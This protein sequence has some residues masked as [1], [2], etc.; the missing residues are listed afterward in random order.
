MNKRHLIAFDLVVS[1]PNRRRLR[2]DVAMNFALDRS[3]GN[4]AR[5]DIAQRPALADLKLSHDQ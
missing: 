4:L 5:G 2:M 1:L 3:R